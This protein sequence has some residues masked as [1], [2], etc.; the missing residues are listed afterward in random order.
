MYS[1][2]SIHADRPHEI[3]AEDF[4]VL[5][6]PV[7]ANSAGTIEN[8]ELSYPTAITGLESFLHSLAEPARPAVLAVLGDG[9]RG[10]VRLSRAGHGPAPLDL[11]DLAG[12]RVATVAPL[13]DALGST[14]LW[15]GRDATGRE[16]RSAVLFARVRDGFGGAT[17]IVRLP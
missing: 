15:D 17:R 10:A 7:M 6:G 16:V 8:A 11:Y 5:F 2:E 12:R 14:W 9:S 13:A 3:F 1:G 4:R